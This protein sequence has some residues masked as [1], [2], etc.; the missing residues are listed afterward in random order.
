MGGDWVEEGVDGPI[1]DLVGVV[2]GSQQGV[3]LTVR[4]WSLGVV[5]GREVQ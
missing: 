4:V 5:A 1:P 3:V 2:L